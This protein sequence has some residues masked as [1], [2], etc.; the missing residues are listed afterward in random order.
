MST[1]ASAGPPQK[2]AREDAPSA[3]SG[4]SQSQG[5][6]AINNLLFTGS[7]VDLSVAVSR[8][9]QKSFFAQQS[10][11][12]GASTRMI[13]VSNSGSSFVSLSNSFLN[14]KV[15][16]NDPAQAISWGP[17]GSACNIFN[18]VSISSRDGSILES[19]ARA[20]VCALIYDSTQRP[21]HWKETVGAAAGYRVPIEAG[22]TNMNSIPA[23]GSRTYSIPLSSL[24]SLARSDKLMPSHLMS[25]MRFEFLHESP[26]VAG[27]WTGNPSV[28]GFVLSDL[29]ISMCCTALSDSAL[30]S[31]SQTAAT[32][33][34]SISYQGFH[35][36][37][38]PLLSASQ[39]EIRKSASRVLA[40]Y[41]FV[42]PAEGANLWA[43]DFFSS[44]GNTLTKYQV[45]LGSLY[46]PQAPIVG[47]VPADLESALYTHSMKHLGKLGTGGRPC[48]NVT[49][50][51]WAGHTTAGG[52]LQ[53]VCTS[54]ERASLE[55]QQS[56]VSSNNSR[57]LVVE[58]ASTEVAGTHNVVFVQVYESVAQVYLN[59]VSTAS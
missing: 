23:L 53:I 8:T 17:N 35:T 1:P 2:R 43:T 24:F 49:F 59:N 28:P 45:R 16:N 34:L 31:I 5:I 33:G 29:S 25:G 41:S 58:L 10:Y 6:L 19:T 18:T 38:S 44:P 30:R 22:D 55:G 15:S 51:K 39:D 7:G 50:S 27:V 40:V 13:C 57:S 52:G 20:N 36:Q 37:E 21:Q 12:S 56:G 3:P 47:G 14:F 46:Y 32:Q 9:S 42:R 48:S 11:T 54:L 26:V 4:N